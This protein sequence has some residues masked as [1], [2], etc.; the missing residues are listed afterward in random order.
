MKE[1]IINFMVK[2]Q[3]LRNLFFKVRTEYV[4]KNYPP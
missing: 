1:K 4:K 2:N 3:Y